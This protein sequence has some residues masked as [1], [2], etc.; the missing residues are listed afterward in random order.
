MGDTIVALPALK[1]I[2]NHF[3]AE[4]K[5]TLLAT[6]SPGVEVS[7]KNLLSDTNYV[8]H[9]L[10]YP[11]GINTWMFLI[12]LARLIHTIH[13][14]KFDIVI[15]L[16]PGQRS[17]F[18]LLRDRVFFRL[19]LIRHHIGFQ[20][21]E[22]QAVYPTKPDGRPAPVP[23]EASFLLE[24]LTASGLATGRKITD[25]LPPPDL[26]LSPGEL[27]QA[28]A[29]LSAK[30]NNPERPLVAIAPGV[31]QPVNQW[32]VDRY[33]ALGS[34]LV[35]KECCDLIIVGGSK[36]RPVQEQLLNHWG[37]GIGT[38]GLFNP[39]TTAALLSHCQLFVGP[40]SGPMHLASAAGIPC[41]AI[42]SDRDNPGRWHPLGQGHEI[43]R[44]PV[45]CGGCGFSICPRPDHLCMT[46]VTVSEVLAVV[47]QQL[48]RLADHAPARPLTTQPLTHNI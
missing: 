32:P 13:R 39:R 18:A 7:S 40:D 44:H 1:W 33:A 3:G 20:P 37:T 5:I 8:D 14:Q 25:P 38:A 10:E 27:Q 26:M 4:S 36:D 22:P 6:Q 43:I 46:S 24:R 42:F 35:Q 21:F 29:W 23:S 28:K 17:K 30:R 9:F 2:R 34:A 12:S 45:V 11:S 19:C 47:L 16:A 31:K 41:V 48:T 15:N